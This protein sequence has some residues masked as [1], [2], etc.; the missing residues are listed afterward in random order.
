MGA[1][2]RYVVKLERRAEEELDEVRAFEARAIVRAIW[3]LENEAETVTR[4]RKPLRQPIAVLPH[5]SWEMRVGDYRVL[6]EV[7]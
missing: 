3:A 1:A 7:K 4:H 6:Y 5:A 2:S